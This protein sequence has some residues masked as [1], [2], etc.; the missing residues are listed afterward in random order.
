MDEVAPRG[1]RRDDRRSAY[2]TRA[3]ITALRGAESDEDYAGL[4]TL[5]EEGPFVKREETPRDVGP[6]AIRQAMGE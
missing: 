5:L 4:L 1:S 2:H 3:I 6:A